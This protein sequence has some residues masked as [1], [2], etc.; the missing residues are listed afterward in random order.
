MAIAP[1][2]IGLRLVMHAR[3]DVLEDACFLVKVGFLNN[4]QPG[5]RLR[6]YRQRCRI[7]NPPVTPLDPVELDMAV[8]DARTDPVD[9]YP[10]YLSL[11]SLRGSRSEAV[12]AG[13]SHVIESLRRR[14]LCGVRDGLKGATL[15]TVLFLLCR[16][17]VR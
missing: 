3:C 10:Q 17:G 4:L 5:G 12:T 1:T 9:T 6:C 16:S 7:D 15:Q 13:Q 14:R 11:E 2:V 8:V